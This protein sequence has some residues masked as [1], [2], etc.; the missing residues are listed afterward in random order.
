[1]VMKDHLCPFGL[2]ARD[3][4]IRE[5]FDVDDRWLRTRVQT[6]AFMKEQGVETTP[7][8]FINGT[9]LVAMMMCDAIS[10]NR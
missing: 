2:N 5:G 8:V 7:Q 1:M 6:D 9:L 3:L 10:A 4:L